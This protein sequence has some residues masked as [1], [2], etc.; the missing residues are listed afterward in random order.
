[1]II[2]SIFLF[3]TLFI[4]TGSAKVA[5]STDETQLLEQL[6]LDLT[7][8]EVV[9]RLRGLTVNEP[10]AT[11]YVTAIREKRFGD[12][13]WA[14]HHVTGAVQNGTFSEVNQTIFQAIENDAIGYRTYYPEQYSEALAIYANTSNADTRTDILNLISNVKAETVSKMEKRVT[15]GIKCSAD[16][17]AYR[18]SCYR[19]LELMSQA[20]TYIG[21]TRRV[22]TYM[23]CNLRV[24][25]YGGGTPDVTHH[26]AHLVARLIEE[27]CSRCPAHCDAVKVSGFSPRNSGH[28][29]ICLSSKDDGCR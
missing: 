28:R 27:Q 1:M 9:N 8:D 22:Y 3:S 4:F 26:T 20:K 12:A 2:T 6:F 16:H 24:G 7:I 25:P 14:R 15:Y 5:A 21:N 10:W 23:S 11:E 13:I 18:S 29:K 19:L 17:L